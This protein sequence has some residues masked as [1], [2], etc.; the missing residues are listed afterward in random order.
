MNALNRP[1]MGPLSHVEVHDRYSGTFVLRSPYAALYR[2]PW[3]ADRRPSSHVKRSLRWWPLH[4]E[5]HLAAPAL[6][7]SKAGRPSARPC[8]NGTPCGPV[9]ARLLLQKYTFTPCPT[10]RPR[11][12]LLKRVSLTVPAFLLKRLLLQEEHATRT[13][14]SACTA[15]WAQLLAGHEPGESGARRHSNPA[16]PSSMPSTWRRWWKRPGLDWHRF[17]PDPSPRE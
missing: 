16:A 1:D 10:P 2:L 8:W 4:H 5:T 17:P 15:F 3:P 9:A 7:C 11:K 12:W 14:Q 13:V 6:T